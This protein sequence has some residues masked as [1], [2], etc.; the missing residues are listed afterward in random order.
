MTQWPN[1]FQLVLPENNERLK[2]LEIDTQLYMKSLNAIIF[3]L[4]PTLSK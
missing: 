1:L 4:K 3:F 2:I